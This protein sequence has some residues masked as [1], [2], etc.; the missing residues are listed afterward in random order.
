MLNDKQWERIAWHLP[1]KKGDPGRSAKDNRLFLEGVLW[2]ARV[3]A[4]TSTCM[5]LKRSCVSSEM[6]LRSGSTSRW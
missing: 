2:I 5:L 1:G 6:I 3:G 4:N